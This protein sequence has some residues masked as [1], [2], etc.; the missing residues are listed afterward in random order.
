MTSKVL[1]R[2]S[3]VAS[4]MIGSE[5]DD[6]K[7]PW[8]P[9]R[10]NFPKFQD[11]PKIPG[12]PDGAAWVWGPDDYLGRL[13]LL[14]PKRVL[15]ASKEIKTGEIISVKYISRIHILIRGRQF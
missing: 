6:N 8:N 5:E 13:N 15:E 4:A 1:S 12:A 2:L 3:Q 10:K 14:T 7:F 11:L 9:D